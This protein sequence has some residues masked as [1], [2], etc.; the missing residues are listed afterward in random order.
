MT[1]GRKR[2]RA[3]AV[4]VWRERLLCVE[5]RD[6]RTR[7][8][9]LFPPGGAIEPGETAAEA[10]VRETLEETGYRVRLQARA[11]VS[12]SYPYTWNGE[13]IDVSTEFFA[14]ELIDPDAQ[15]ALVNDASYLEA[16]HWIAL[17]HVPQALGFNRDILAAVLALLP[18]AQKR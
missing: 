3:C 14:A 1:Q 7:V 4:C 9:H 5:L 6:P 12:A 2:T 15:P 13:P 8:A 18:V 17:S 11:P 16:T 10:A